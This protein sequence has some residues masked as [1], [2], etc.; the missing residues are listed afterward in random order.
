[1]PIICNL[2]L[3]PLT[4]KFHH[5]FIGLPLLHYMESVQHNLL[6]IK[7]FC[8][9]GEYTYQKGE[10]LEIFV[11]F[12]V[13]PSIY[14]G[15]IKIEVFQKHFW[16]FERIYSKIVKAKKS[17]QHRY[18]LCIPGWETGQF[19]S[20]QLLKVKTTIISPAESVSK[21]VFLKVLE[22]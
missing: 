5:I 10:P 6:S 2:P 19:S 8:L 11:L 16:S 18:P 17:S 14:N 7:N 12:K 15:S 22:I 4:E 20:E 9:T 3:T 21:E 13:I 1:M